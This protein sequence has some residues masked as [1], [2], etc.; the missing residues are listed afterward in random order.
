MRILAVSSKNKITDL[1]RDKAMI[2]N[3]KSPI[4]PYRNIAITFNM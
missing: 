2:F 3:K 1:L 4:K